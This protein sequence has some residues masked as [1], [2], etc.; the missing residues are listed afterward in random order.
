MLFTTDRDKLFFYYDMVL[1][2]RRFMV[3]PQK[4]IPDELQTANATPGEC[5]EG[6]QAGS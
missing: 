5:D 6:P 4:D 1:T 2:F 3:E